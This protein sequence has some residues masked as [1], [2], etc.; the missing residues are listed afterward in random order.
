MAKTKPPISHSKIDWPVTLIP[1]LMVTS[2]CTIFVIF[3]DESRSVVDKVHYF[4]VSRFGAYYILLGLG[5]FMMSMYVAFSKRGN[6]RLGN[7]N[8]PKYS[9]FS[10][11]S[12]V[13]TATMAADILFFALH[14][15]GF[16]FTSMPLD[17]DELSLAQRQLWASTY[18]LFH[19]GAI[20]W[21]FF[22]LPSAAYG[23][24]LFVKGRSRQTLSEACRPILGSKVDGLWGK[25]IDVVGIFGMIAGAATTFSLATPLIN[26]ALNQVLGLPI[27]KWITMAILVTIAIVYTLAV[28]FS[29]KGIAYV[30][31]LC[32]FFFVLLIISFLA[33]GNVLYTIETTA[34]ALGN[35]INNFFRMATWMDPLRLSAGKGIA[36]GTDAA[37]FPQTWTV[38]YWAY[39]IAWCVATPFFIGKISEGRTIRQ[40]IL[41]SFVAGLGGTYASISVFGNYGL[42]QQV[43]G[44]IEVAQQLASGVS[45]SEIIIDIFR[46]LPFPDL[47]LGLLVIAMILFY[48][49]TFDALTMVMATYSYKNLGKKEEPKP[50]MKA[51]WSMLFVILPVALLF[52]EQTL[53]QLQTVSIVAALPI[54]VV[55]I[56]IISG[57]LKESKQTAQSK[58]I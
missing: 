8:K 38:F 12:M 7:L 32:V 6:I 46:T 31:K 9:N 41:G 25:V 36:V 16:Y 33:G 17:F 39:W 18:P 35:L 23:Y 44:R 56:I 30:A 50:G 15:W 13:F 29:Y 27:D 57:F 24:M 37:A 1:L 34:T 53:C 14:E 28:V 47:A 55:L 2:L 4:L 22:I 43:T 26:L 10:W 48:A 40:T 20:P 19:W 3:P 51:F 58:E 11:G 45:Q 54:S 42:Y 49:S 5:F 21:S 52:S